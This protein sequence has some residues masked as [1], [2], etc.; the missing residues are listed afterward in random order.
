MREHL[1]PGP[2]DGNFG[3]PERQ[4]LSAGFQDVDGSGTPGTYRQCLDF[5]CG[6]PFFHEAKER[7]FRSIVETDPV[8]ILDAGCGAGSDLA[9]LASRIDA[10]CSLAGLDS[11]SSLLRMAWDRTRE[12]RGRCSLIRGDILDIPCRGGAFDAVRIDRVLQ[13][14]PGPVRGVRELVRVL[15]PGGT[16]VA[17]DNDWDT[18]RID[19]DDRDLALR[20]TRFFRDSFA[21]GLVGREL[22]EIFAD[23][24]LEE[25]RVEPRTLVLHDLSIAW[26]LFDLSA[27]LQRTQEKGIMTPAEVLE[28]RAELSRRAE[29]GT[30]SAGYTG[31]LVW[32]TKPAKRE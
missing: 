2:Q 1:P 22:P 25:I 6:I 8:S 24:G 27:L 29:E 10:G 17:F 3:N 11:S 20:L 18:F 32:G 31:Y 13:H 5:I 28:V 15:V 19:L 21:S 23:C 12:Y 4:F 16:L 30:F 26:Q 14:L 7:S 9:A